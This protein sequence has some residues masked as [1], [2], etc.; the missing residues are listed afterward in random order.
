MLDAKQIQAV[1]AVIEEAS[2]ERAA[3]I[4]CITQSAISQRVKTLENLLGQAL[5]VRSNPVKATP[6]GRMILGYYQQ[7]TLLQHELLDQITDDITQKQF[8]SRDKLRIALNVDSLDSWFI[9]AV[10]PIVNEYKLLLELKLDDQE[11][12]HEFLKNG[13]VIGCISSSSQSLQGCQCIPLGQMRYY[14]VCSKEFKNEYFK[15][16]LNADQFR[17]APGIEFNHKDRLQQTY[18]KLFWNVKANEYPFHQVPSSS[19]YVEFLSKGM[20]WGMLSNVK[21]KEWLASKDLVI[22]NPDNYLSVPLYWHV[23]SFKSELIKNISEHIVKSAN[24]LL[25]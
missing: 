7:M 13:E 10:T 25:S 4:L 24:R 20:G 12:T 11:Q 8:N 18:L 22:L 9:E 6:A 3:E 15:G 19:G 17:Q 16:K 5:I 23:W 21:S 1:A 2:F 14:G